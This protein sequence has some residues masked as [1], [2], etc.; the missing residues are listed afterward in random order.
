[1][2]KKSHPL[3]PGLYALCDDTLS[4]NLPMIEKVYQLLQGG[5]TV[6]QMRLKQTPEK[7]ALPLLGQAVELCAAHG[8]VCLVN[9]RAD[10]AMASGA[11]GVHL[12]E[13]D[14]PVQEARRLLGPSALI[15]RTVRDPDMMQQAARA[16]ADYVG[17]GPIF[18][19]TTKRVEARALGLEGL[20]ACLENA[21]LP[22]VAISGIDVHNIEAVAATGAWGAAVGSA[23]YGASLA[24]KAR[25]LS[26]AFEQGRNR[27]KRSNLG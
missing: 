12:G 6:L 15:G 23:L 9:D 5:V 19:T 21:P 7:E 8:C 18:P 26:A 25:R 2:P 22:V 1:M 17:L 4:P 24:E 20:R 14:L 3:P 10:W 16:G 11:A 13:D 27:A